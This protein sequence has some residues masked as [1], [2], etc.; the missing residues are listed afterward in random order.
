MSFRHAGTQKESDT[1]TSAGSAQCLLWETK[2][3]DESK[4]PITLK[5]RTDGPAGY[6]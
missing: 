5:I 3:A 4:R 1:L 2:S 6:I